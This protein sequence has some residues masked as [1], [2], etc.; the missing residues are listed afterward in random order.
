[1]PVF[2]IAGPTQEFTASGQTRVECREYLPAETSAAVT[3]RFNGR[4]DALPKLIIRYDTSPQNGGYLVKN[5]IF[6]DVPQK[7]GA[8]RIFLQTDAAL[9][10]QVSTLY[11]RTGGQL[12]P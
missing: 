2:C 5:Q 1:M 12:V 9:V 6:L 11:Q 8:D 7:S 3:L 10:S 4:P